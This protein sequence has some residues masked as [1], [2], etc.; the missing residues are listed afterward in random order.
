MGSVIPVRL[1][2]SRAGIYLE[3]Y[4]LYRTKLTRDVTAL[5]SQKQ[6]FLRTCL[7]NLLHYYFRHN[8]QPG[9]ESPFV[10]NRQG[11]GAMAEAEFKEVLITA[12]GNSVVSVHHLFESDK[13]H[14]ES[15]SVE[16]LLNESTRTFCIILFE[17]TERSRDYPFLTVAGGP[18]GGEPI[19]V[20]GTCI[21]DLIIKSGGDVYLF[22]CK[23]TE[24]KEEDQAGNSGTIF[25]YRTQLY[26]YGSLIKRMGRQRG[27][28]ARL[29]LATD[30]S[31]IHQALLYL[32][33]DLFRNPDRVIRAIAKMRDG[34]RAPVSCLGTFHYLNESEEHRNE[35]EDLIRNFVLDF[36]HGHYLEKGA[37][38]LNLPHCA[39]LSHGI[40]EE[41][42]QLSMK[43]V[44]RMTHDDYLASNV[45]YN[46][47]RCAMP[48]CGLKNYL[49]HSQVSLWKDNTTLEAILKE[50]FRKDRGDDRNLHGLERQALEMLS[51]LLNV[52]YVPSVNITIEDAR[53]LADV[54]YI[55]RTSSSA[56][57]GE[58]KPLAPALGN[59]LMPLQVVFAREIV[60][61]L[62]DLPRLSIIQSPT[63]SGKMLAAML[64]AN[65]LL[66]KHDEGLIIVMVPKKTL[67]THVL[68]E[69]RRFFVER[70]AL[71]DGHEDSRRKNE[72]FYQEYPILALR[73]NDIRVY[74]GDT[75]ETMTI[76]D[77]G[78]II[79]TYEYAGELLYHQ[80]ERFQNLR[81][82]VCDEIH[83]R[84][85]QVR[86]NSMVEK[87]YLPF[88]DFV[89]F[90]ELVQRGLHVLW[91]SGTM[92]PY[93]ANK[94]QSMSACNQVV[95]CFKANRVLIDADA[96]VQSSE[97][98]IRQIVDGIQYDPA[99]KTLSLSDP[100]GRIRRHFA[101]TYD[102]HERT[103]LLPIFCYSKWMAE[104]L[105]CALKTK[106]RDMGF[107]D[108][109]RNI[110]VYT[111]TKYVFEKE[112]IE[113]AVK[114]AA[115]KGPV[116]LI[117]TNV[118]AEG[119]RLDTRIGLLL[120]AYNAQQKTYFYDDDTMRQMASRIARGFADGHKI[121]GYFRVLTT[122]T[123]RYDSFARHDEI[124]RFL[125]LNTRLSAETRN[126]DIREG[127]AV[128]KSY[129]PEQHILSEGDIELYQERLLDQA[130]IDDQLKITFEGEMYLR[131]GLWHRPI[132]DSVIEELEDNIHL[133]LLFAP[134][135]N[136]EEFIDNF[137]DDS[138]NQ[139][140][141]FYG[142]KN[143]HA[144]VFLH[145]AIRLDD[146]AKPAH[147]RKDPARRIANLL[148][149]YSEGWFEAMDARVDRIYRNYGDEIWRNISF[150]FRE[151]DG[152]SKVL[153]M[154]QII[155]YRLMFLNFRPH[156]LNPEDRVT[157]QNV[158]L[159]ANQGIVHNPNKTLRNLRFYYELLIKKQT[160]EQPENN[161]KRAIEAMHDIVGS[162]YGDIAFSFYPKRES[163]LAS[164]ISA[165][166]M[167]IL[168]VLNELQ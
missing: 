29:Q 66:A 23:Y 127:Y 36:V 43:S 18:Q 4:S 97:E 84:L 11:I 86:E 75:I 162:V 101:E 124:Q 64:F 85:M 33:P 1:I 125:L 115:K 41:L 114:D 155:A 48:L 50:R 82:V 103:Y 60:S 113:N 94:I 12:F 90:I 14:P 108:M 93:W 138:Q 56:V 121:R 32:T 79:S 15:L 47:P 69:F 133:N 13:P 158:L 67:A 135:L 59:A 77:R 6:A 78:I 120:R 65:A 57:A 107:A 117:T 8:L 92:P 46:C 126:V 137:M 102:E 68:N 54:K 83:S 70:A 106:F 7:N 26:I 154:L 55:V 99:R 22:D 2:S 145:L 31:A 143:W 151:S 112:T 96:S 30:I 144:P 3:H 80:D 10:A 134:Y 74:H 168:A 166:S 156:M 140:K 165:K 71:S 91:M 116:I 72:V 52:D 21:P 62:D 100:Q 147:I 131:F 38:A 25:Q 153:L 40:G 44:F 81:G 119:I 104:Q 39:P 159:D 5:D 149:G 49:I 164:R 35:I 129:F 157:Y 34:R 105:S 148:H 16:G 130:Y 89:S 17:P 20:S 45:I 95:S 76:P 128:V 163:E 152:K 161:I 160:A 58:I 24:P 9:I 19:E 150:K 167:A 122:S 37:P 142:R 53:W 141:E 88:H 27:G 28:A 51:R 87:H 98:C 139:V 132:G 73:D 146:P 111:A 123:E 42:N 118:I 109:E 136:N 63:N 61:R 110:H